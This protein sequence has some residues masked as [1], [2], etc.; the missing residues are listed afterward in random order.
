[1]VEGWGRPWTPRSADNPRLTIP[2]PTPQRATAR[3]GAAAAVPHGVASAT[4]SC[5][6]PAKPRR[7]LEERLGSRGSGREGRLRPR[8]VRMLKWVWAPTRWERA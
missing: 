4:P 1:M 2:G 5:R 3:R 6:H 7:R 8:G